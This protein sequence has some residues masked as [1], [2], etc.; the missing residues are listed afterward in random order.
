M[1]AVACGRPASIPLEYTPSDIAVVVS[2]VDRKLTPKIVPYQGGEPI[3]VDTDDGEPVYTWILESEDFVSPS[4]EALSVETL[5]GISVRLEDGP[6]SA[7]ACGRCMT[8]SQI[9]PQLVNEGESCRIPTFA[10]G[11]VWIPREEGFVCSGD[12]DSGIC[13]T[14]PE[15]DQKL[16][17]EVRRALRLDWPG[18]CACPPPAEAAPTLSELLVRPISPSPDPYPMSAFAQDGA[19]R[20][21]AF[22]RD[23]AFLHDPTTMTSDF[24]PIEGWD[25]EVTHAIALRDG[26]GFIVAGEEFNTG[27]LNA[28]RFD[29]FTLDQG[30]LVGPTE[31]TSDHLA[32]PT[33][34]AYYGDHPD[35]PLYVLGSIR[36]NLGLIEP[37]IFACSDRTLGCQQV[38]LGTCPDERSLST[39][40]DLEVLPDGTAFALG[41][42]AFYARPPNAP[43]ASNPSPADFWDCSQHPDPWTWRGATADPVRTRLF[44]ALGR[45][46]DRIFVCAISSTDACE[47][48]YAVVLTA[49]VTSSAG[50]VV[51]PEWEVVYRGGDWS[52]CR[53]F[54]DLPSD[55]TGIRL[56]LSG[57]RLVDFDASGAVTLESWIGTEYGEVASLHSFYDL[58]VPGWSMLQSV[59]SQIFLKRDGEPLSQV[60]GGPSIVGAHYTVAAAIG[61]GDFL[62]FG[63]PEGPVRVRVLESTDGFPAT[64]VRVLADPTGAFA[65]GGSIRDL[66]LD[67]E[68]TGAAGGPVVLAVGER[69]GDTLL[70]RLTIGDADITS[71]E[72]L[73]PPASVGDL[74]AVRVAEAAPGRFVVALEGTRLLGIGGGAVTDLEI[75]FDDP[76]TEEVEVR[77]NAGVNGCNGNEY[78]LDA[79]RDVVGRNGAA[80]VVGSHQLAF[81]VVGDR[82][83]RFVGPPSIE[84]S[85]AMAICSDDIVLAGRGESVDLAGVTLFR[86]QFWSIADVPEPDAEEISLV[87]RREQG[88]TEFGQDEITSIGIYDIQQG[89][90]RAVFRDSTTGRSR[91]HPALAIALSNGLLPRF[92]VSEGLEAARPPFYPEVVVQSD[93]GYIL[94]GTWDSR[95]ALG[96]P[97]S[98]R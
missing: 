37:A 69:A 41:D 33:S 31:I 32:R 42:H 7:G 95:L 22:S 67:T 46:G 6:P 12:A 8:P 53:A 80:W 65:D 97:Q 4:G 29:R 43:P 14:G 64:D 91:G 59:E 49:T 76:D 90:P 92:F 21:A 20:F 10:S 28:Y 71:F 96:V 84:Y 23:A 82:V 77:P 55:P 72:T 27:A 36:G 61:E 35:F 30:R 86:L 88:L 93:G 26:S 89:Y 5:A 2:T 52:R 44:Q 68:A 13:S 11:A 16:V 39:I 24:M 1:L 54:L 66:V 81:R 57:Q 34:M 62:A 58:E 70:L 47:P 48:D 83:E 60:Y 15:A 87:L 40:L 56:Q 9:A 73:A 45:A 17:E 50:A 94:Y 38:G 85:A 51:E 25:V 75:P 18:A 63:H 3:E 79:W 19:G 78:R 74:G 98:K